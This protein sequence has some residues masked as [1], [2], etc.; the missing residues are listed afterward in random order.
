MYLLQDVE[1]KWIIAGDVFGNNIRVEE[2]TAQY[3]KYPDSNTTVWK[4][5]VGQSFPEL[6][7]TSRVIC[8]RKNCDPEEGN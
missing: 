3:Q 4:N 6:R 7:L 2:D 5:S 8:Y 1:G